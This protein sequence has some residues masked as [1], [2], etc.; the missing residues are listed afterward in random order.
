MSIDLFPVSDFD[1]WAET[2]D[3]S[4]AAEEFLFVGYQQALAKTVELAQ[5]QPG[6]SVL[7]LGTGTGNLAALLVARGCEVWATDFSEAMLVKARA[8]VPLAHFCLYDLRSPWPVG[9]PN[10]FDRIVS[11]YVFHHFEL[12]EKLRLV[13]ELVHKHLAPDG[14]LVIADVA[15]RD[16]RALEAL[17]EQV[18][19]EWED[20]YYWI[21]EET[22]PALKRSR[23]K[24]KYTQ[25]SSCAGIFLMRYSVG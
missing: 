5:A 4:V 15:F 23:L 13:K 12:E 7:D 21:A 3:D 6:M 1:E 17:R 10:R 14:R 24:I 18:G 25:V 9:L 16:R 19:E 20:E 22:L 8:K 11:A 2:Y